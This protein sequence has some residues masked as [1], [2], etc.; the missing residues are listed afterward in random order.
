M[1]IEL[2]IVS[3]V[4]NE[5]LHIEEMIKSVLE[6]VPFFIN[7]ELIII[8][9][10]SSDRTNKICKKLERCHTEIRLY[11]NIGTGKV[12]GTI[13]GLKKASKNWVKCIDGDDFVDFTK[14]Q[15]EEFNCDA[16]YHD[17]YKYVENKKLKYV[18]TSSGLANAQS[19]W[20][21]D[22]RS[23]PKGMFFFKKSLIDCED[24]HDFT[25]FSYEDAFINFLIGKNAKKIKKINK[26]LYFYRQ[27]ERNFYGDTKIGKNKIMRMRSRLLENYTIIREL[28]P[29]HPIN[30]NMLTYCDALQKITWS[31]CLRLIFNPQLLI[32]A[33]VYRVYSKL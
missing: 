24:M 6:T 25:R 31:N 28:Y 32:K 16:F 33:L 11:E 20:N 13:M 15:I 19:D 22:L 3:V 29:D 26:P 7:L 5:Q 18:K 23:I 8:D 9:D 27:H 10:H 1:A 30:K 12:C 4:K 21:Y 2:S 17:Y 14:L